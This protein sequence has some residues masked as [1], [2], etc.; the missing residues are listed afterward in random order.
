MGSSNS[1]ENKNE[2]NKASNDSSD[3]EYHFCQPRKPHHRKNR[4]KS[5]DLPQP[6]G[7]Q[8]PSLKPILSVAEGMTIDSEK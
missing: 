8:K 7:V 4:P 5:E 2:G 6:Q 3:D 1:A